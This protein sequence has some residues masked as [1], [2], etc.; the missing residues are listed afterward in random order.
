MSTP[1]DLY[2][3][4]E[5]RRSIYGLSK[6]EVVSEEKLESIIAH[7]VK[8]IPSP[9]NSQSGRVV[10]LMREHHDKL[11]EITKEVLKERVS[12]KKFPKTEQKLNSFQSGYGTILF[13]EDKETVK[14]LQ[15]RFP[16]YSETFPLW[17][18]QSSG[19][20]QYTIW[21]SLEMEGLGA[22]LQHYNPLID[23]QV[24]Q[25][26]NIPESWELISQM[27]FGKPTEAPGEKDFKPLEERMKVFK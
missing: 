10:L 5:N 14:D 26:W 2:K 15:D 27:P 18:Q 3:A 19:M 17:S 8:H 7:A 23:E 1:K 12:E 20:L 24:K 11:W 9:F 4:I 25:E 22:S 6:E 13:F 21:T 16:K